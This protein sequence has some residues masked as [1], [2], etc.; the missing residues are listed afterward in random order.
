MMISEQL[1]ILF[2]T[3][4]VN[5]LTFSIGVMD[6]KLLEGVMESYRISC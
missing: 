2:L 6:K 1:E 5:K 3:K 4:K